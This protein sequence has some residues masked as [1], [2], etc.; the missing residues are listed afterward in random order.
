MN[1]FFG[2]LGFM[3]QKLRKQTSPLLNFHSH[4]RSFVCDHQIDRPENSDSSNLS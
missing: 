1:V 3:Q 4:P 2:K